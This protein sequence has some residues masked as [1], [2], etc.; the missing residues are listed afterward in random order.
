MNESAWENLQVQL[1]LLI[2]TL[3]S[4]NFVNCYAI[5]AENDYAYRI[6]LID[7]P[8]LISASQFN[9]TGAKQ[10]AQQWQQTNLI[11]EINYFYEHINKLIYPTAIYQSS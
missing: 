8:I 7:K 3:Y 9:L 11:Y 5:L 4:L 6:G 1:V 10:I 2:A